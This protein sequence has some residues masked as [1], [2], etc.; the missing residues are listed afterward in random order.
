MGLPAITRLFIGICLLSVASLFVPF[1]ASLR[2]IA[3][4]FL[5][6]MLPGLAV[7]LVM[8]ERRPA[9][10]HKIVAAPLLSPILLSLAVIAIHRLTGSV[11]ASVTI[12]I[13]LFEAVLAVA[14]VRRPASMQIPPAPLGLT[15]LALSLLFGGIVVVCYLANTHLVIRSDAW[16]H[17][18]VVSE[19]LDRGIPPMEPRLPDVPIRY[20][21]LYHLFIAATKDLTGLGLFTALGVF[22]VVNAFVFPWLAA[23]AVSLYTSDRRTIVLSTLIVMA[24]LESAAWIL[25]PAGLVR[26]FVGE[27]RGFEVLTGLLRDIDINSHHV[28]SFLSPFEGVDR[29]GNWMVNLLD[30]FLTITAFSFALNV[31]LLAFLTAASAGLR[32]RVSKR[33][34]FLVFLLSLE[35][36]LFH[37]IIGTELILGIV[38][39]GALVA[40]HARLR[41]HGPVPRA[42]A[43]AFPAAAAA[44]GLCAFPYLAS[45]LA[46]GAPGAQS[47][48]TIHIG[49]RNILTIVLPLAVLYCPAKRAL[50]EIFSLGSDRVR[51]AA[52][53]IVT[54]AAICI[55]AN[56]PTRNESKLIFPL[57]LLLS[58]PI[59]RQV[60]ETIRGAAGARRA[61]LVAWTLL[62]FLV[63]PALTIRGFVLDRPQNPVEMRRANVTAEDR[64]VFQWIAANTPVNAVVMENAN[65]YK[66]MPIYAHRRNFYPNPWAVAVLGYGGEKV[67][68]Y[69][70]V[71]DGFFGPAGPR[72]ADLET[73][74]AIGAP[75]Y[76]VLWRE[77]WEGSAALGE[78]FDRLPDLFEPVFRSG[79]ARIYRTRL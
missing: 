72:A 73:L 57:F 71:R 24:G 69:L 53:W 65:N 32:E 37:V 1:P 58:P 62:L 60:V 17:A 61:A 43:F 44:A 63:P 42:H 29:I 36:I 39:A 50:R 28:I 23:R 78:R 5:T 34:V 25:W 22:N 8:G 13:L 56:L 38:G 75:V 49:L 3:G 76:I 4:L 54:L 21:W 46:G 31:F 7:L 47:T 9:G 68:R 41:E 11:D 30:K 35:A 2:V 19:I 20:M 74:R 10:L 14:I 70:A 15:P 12:S 27:H 55:F 6:Y 48:G 67:E 79:V 59:A 64:A 18:S 33:A 77:D 26:A 52:A 40:L 51:I 16:Y 66:M 45:L